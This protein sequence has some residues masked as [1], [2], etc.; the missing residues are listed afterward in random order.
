[1]IHPLLRLAVSEPHLLGDHVEAYAALVG[2]EAKDVSTSWIRRIV[3][4]AVAGVMGLVGLILV[5]VALLFW[6]AVPTDQY[7]AGW[8]LVVIPLVPLAVA[9]GC[10]FAAKSK[11]ISTAFEK[12]RQQLNADMAMLREVNT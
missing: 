4:Y 10:A 8:A 11:P 6:A 12:V 5:G 2:E 9:A 1:M 7:N 3:L